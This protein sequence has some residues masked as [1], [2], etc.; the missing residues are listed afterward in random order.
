MQTFHPGQIVRFRNPEADEVGLTYTVVE[1]R[2]PRV[3]IKAN[4]DLPFPPTQTVALDDIEAVVVPAT[5]EQ[6]ARQ[7]AAYQA[8]D[9]AAL[10]RKDATSGILTFEQFQASKKHVDDI[11]EAVGFDDEL[12]V[13]GGHIYALGCY[14]ED[15]ADGHYLLIERSDW[16]DADLAKLERIL[17][18]S[19]YLPEATA[20]A[21]AK[22]RAV[23]RA[24]LNARIEFRQTH[25]C[26]KVEQ[27]LGFQES[28]DEWTLFDGDHDSRI[29]VTDDRDLQLGFTVAV[30][31]GEDASLAMEIISHHDTLADAKARA[32]SL[33]QEV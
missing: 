4:V 3:L 2:D 9:D 23:A 30:Y 24:A 28:G 15:H 19:W 13:R 17:Y 18:E 12:G 33:Y 22:E 31:S 16:L 1:L 26:N 14:I 29:T 20:E 11:R 7:A 25:V 8:D 6:M 10:A 32:I 21:H 27:A 5:A